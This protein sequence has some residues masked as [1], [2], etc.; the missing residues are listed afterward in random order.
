M[1]KNF[2]SMDKK[3]HLQKSGN[4][5]FSTSKFPDEIHDIVSLD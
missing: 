2:I 4:I 1:L 3:N 5:L